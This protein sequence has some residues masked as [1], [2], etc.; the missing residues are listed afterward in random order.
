M[1]IV[2]IG[3]GTLSKRVD[4]FSGTSVG[5]LS[6]KEF[7]EA[8]KAA[9]EA[10]VCLPLTASS[11]RSI[12]QSLGSLALHLPF[13]LRR[14][15]EEERRH[16]KHCSQTAKIVSGRSSVRSQA[17]SNMHLALHMP[18]DV[19]GSGSVLACRMTRCSWWRQ[20]L[21]Q[22]LTTQTPR[23]LSAPTLQVSAA[24]L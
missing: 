8:T 3:E 16:Q 13:N 24:I 10:L 21:V 9:D 18:V 15:R 12:W 22:R 6:L 14:R 2:H 11:S 1:G 4:E 23:S 17:S 7:E 5:S 20:A 19:R